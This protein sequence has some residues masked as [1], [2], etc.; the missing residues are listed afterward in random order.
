MGYLMRRNILTYKAPPNNE[1]YDLICIH[2]NPRH[3]H[4]AGQLDQVKVQVK[5]RYATDAIRE[6]PLQSKSLRAF[7]F[8]V[9]VFLNIG[10]FARGKTGQAGRG[11][12]EFFVFPRAVLKRIPRPSG[13]EGIRFDPNA[14]WLQKY[15][16][17]EALAQIGTLL[18]VPLPSRE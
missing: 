12:V 10:E 3:K 4:K 14:P 2:P 15:R 16:G 5:S 11:E 13:W 6:F 17:E 18:G 1:G 9:A 7:D 8:V